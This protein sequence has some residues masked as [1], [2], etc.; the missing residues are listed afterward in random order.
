MSDNGAW[1]IKNWTLHK[2]CNLRNFHTLVLRLAPSSVWKKC[3]LLLSL[4]SQQKIILVKN[5]ESLALHQQS[6]TRVLSCTAKYLTC[7]RHC[8][9]SIPRSLR[10]LSF[11]IKKLLKLERQL[12]NSFWGLGQGRV[13]LNCWKNHWARILLEILY[14]FPIRRNTWSA[15][16]CQNQILSGGKYTYH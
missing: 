1:Q 3:F 15:S 6:L 7:T 12:T 4:L 10:I 14:S 8:M 16:S 11:E 5:K 13:E 9:I 2:P